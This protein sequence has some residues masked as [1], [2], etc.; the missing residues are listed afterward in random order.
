MQED[1]IKNDMMLTGVCEE[2]AGNRELRWWR[3]P[4][5]VEREGEEEEEEYF[6]LWANEIA[7]SDYDRLPLIF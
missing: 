1:V 3:T 7:S 5:I 6:S 2:D 4:Q